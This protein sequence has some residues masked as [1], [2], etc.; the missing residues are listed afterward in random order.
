MRTTRQGIGIYRLVAL[1]FSVLWVCAWAVTV[2]TWERDAAGYS[3]G[4][5][6]VAIPLHLVLPFVLGGLVGL[7]RAGTRSASGRV[8]TLV[9]LAFGVVQFGILWLAD[10]L[11]LPAVESEAPFWEMAVGAMV[12]TVIYAA[13]CVVLGVLG[14]KVGRT[15]APRRSDGEAP[16][17][18]AEAGRGE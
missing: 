18:P 2:V 6:P 12:G 14:G 9:G 11:W 8:C 3:V 17:E 15:L 16:R 13:V 1:L 10:V 5:N 7:R 4:M